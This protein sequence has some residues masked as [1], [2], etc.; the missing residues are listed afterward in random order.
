MKPWRER[1]A[2]M[3]ER[4]ANGR[5][6]ACRYRGGMTAADARDL[7][8]FDTCLVGE[9]RAKM[10][11]VVVFVA[12]YPRDPELVRLG[13]DA[14]A[15]SLAWVGRDAARIAPFLDEQLDKIEDRV[16]Q[17]KREQG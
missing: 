5:D 9:Q 17:L 15:F 3:R 8:R 12:D 6:G 4:Y 11:D 10:P 7:Q 2:D 1:I 16:L 13:T 14:M